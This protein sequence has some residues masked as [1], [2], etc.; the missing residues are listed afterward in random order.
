MM[1]SV[2][3][4]IGSI[5]AKAAIMDDRRLK[6]TCILGTGYDAKTAAVAVF[7]EVLSISGYEEKQVDF[8]IATGYGRKSVAFAVV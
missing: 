7:A 6:G 2:G 4:D 8:I 5:T 3:I 1:I